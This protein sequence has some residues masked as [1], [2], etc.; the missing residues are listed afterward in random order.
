MTRPSLAVTATASQVEEHSEGDDLAN[1]LSEIRRTLCYLVSFEDL[2]NVA[3]G[4]QKIVSTP[5]KSPS[6]GAKSKDYAEGQA[7]EDQAIHDGRLPPDP[8]FFSCPASPDILPYLRT[9]HPTS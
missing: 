6:A 7:L 5:G 9:I 1:E 4:Y 8:K 3:I 2:F